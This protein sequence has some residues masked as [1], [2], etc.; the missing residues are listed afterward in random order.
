VVDRVTTVTTPGE[1]VDV[2]V[3]EA[4]VAVHP[5]REELRDRLIA[6]GVRVMPI[7]QMRQMAS[8]A[9]VEPK[10]DPREERIVAVVEYRDGT[11]TD[12]VRAVA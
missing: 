7:E 10:P 12:V 5:A 6:G 3:T 1:T 8:Q 9:A 11:V 4:G 2:L